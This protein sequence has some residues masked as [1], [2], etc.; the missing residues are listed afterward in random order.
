MSVA[1]L[2]NR[3]G[4]YVY[5]GDS[6]AG[7]PARQ[8]QS[9]INQKDADQEAHFRIGGVGPVRPGLSGRMKVPTI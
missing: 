9:K 5:V 2:P 8:S 6:S 1:T 4:E 7:A 3:Q